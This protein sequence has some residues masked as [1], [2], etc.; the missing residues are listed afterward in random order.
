MNNPTSESAPKK[1]R[2]VV[3]GGGVAGLQIATQLGSHFKNVGLVTLV[4]SDSAHVWKPM[5]HTIAAGTR[6]VSQQQT[7]YVAQARA[8]GFIYQPGQMTG[9]DRDARKIT[10][11]P[12]FFPD[13]RVLLAERKLPYDVL[14]MAV[15]SHA[16]DFNTPGVSSHCYMIDTRLQADAFNREVRARIL[17]SALKGGNLSIAIVGGGATG[18]E[19]AAELIQLANTAESYGTKG[20]AARIKIT[21]IESGPRLLAA[22]PEKVSEVTKARLAELGV[23]VR[24]ATK[25]VAATEQ[26]FVLEGGELLVADLKVWSAGVKAPDF[27]N[28][29]GGLETSRNNQ[30]VIG[31]TLQTSRDPNI[32]AVGDCAYLVMPG[33]SAPLPP[34]AQI[35][36]QQAQY[37]TKHLPAWLEKGQPLP[38]FVPRDMGALVSLGS[39]G[40]FGSLGQFGLFKGGFIQGKLAQLSHV[41]LYRSHQAYIH[42]FWRGSLLW[43]VDKINDWLRPTIRL[44]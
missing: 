35:A 21:L 17:Q 7:T 10:L 15:G 20:L 24:V 43:L 33:A 40:A 13:G 27:L 23:T 18:V 9:L 31:D 19:L 5:L 22:F 8:A 41:M 34:T 44:D 4:D 32:F 12:M 42:G 28:Q 36:H 6:D 38:K 3:V 25:V 30:L 11:A 14:V 16:N 39:Y 2:I 1:L 37:L 26:G 29:I